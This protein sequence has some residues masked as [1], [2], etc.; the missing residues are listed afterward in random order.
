MLQPLNK[1]WH[2]DVVEDSQHGIVGALDQDLVAAMEALDQ[3]IL[4]REFERQSFEVISEA[5]GKNLNRL[6]G[7]L[8]RLRAEVL[9]L[10]ASEG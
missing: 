7:Y 2:A 3:S 5:L 10:H 1:F 8:R 6:A 9:N 4:L